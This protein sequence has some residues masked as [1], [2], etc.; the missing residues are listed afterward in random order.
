MSKAELDSVKIE[1]P[2]TRCF[3]SLEKDRRHLTNKGG[4]QFGILPRCPADKKDG[5]PG[6]YKV[7]VFIVGFIA[8]PVLGVVVYLVRRWMR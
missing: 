4:A 6:D 7:T 1:K 2:W 3:A 5:M 8:I